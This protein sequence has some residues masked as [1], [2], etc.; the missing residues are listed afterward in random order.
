MKYNFLENSDGLHNDIVIEDDEGE[1]ELLNGGIALLG[2]E[3]F[4]TPELTNRCEA[5]IRNLMAVNPGLL[6]ETV[7]SWEADQ[8]NYIVLRVFLRGELGL[9]ELFNE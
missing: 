3:A 7:M 5:A 1:F 6:K 2:S 8:T 4:R 9:S